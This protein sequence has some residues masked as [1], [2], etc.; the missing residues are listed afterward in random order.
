MWRRCRSAFVSNTSSRAQ[1]QLS[2]KPNEEIVMK[3]L[4]TGIATVFVLTGVALG[5]TG[6]TLP[7]SPSTPIRQIPAPAQS[8]K[9]KGP[10][11]PKE[12]GGPR[13]A[14]APIN[15]GVPAPTTKTSKMPQRKL[16]AKETGKPADQRPTPKK[17]KERDRPA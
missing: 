2:T 14:K 9:A 17:P 8:D 7:E 10:T 5:D 12:G 3:K 4:L 11:V 16:A 15:L 6:P 1:L 13:L